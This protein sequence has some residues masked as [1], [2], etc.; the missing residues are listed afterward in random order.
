MLQN[1][2]DED[3]TL[4]IEYRYGYFLGK[5]IFTAFLRF[6]FW[7]SDATDPIKYL[8]NQCPYLV[9]CS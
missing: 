3:Q 6:V 4:Q 1:K 2:V 9:H 5:Y 8:Q 7:T